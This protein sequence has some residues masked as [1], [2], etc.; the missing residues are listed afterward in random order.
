MVA[1]VRDALAVS[2]SEEYA[3]WRERHRL[4]SEENRRKAGAHRWQQF[5]VHLVDERGDCIPD[6]YLEL[7]TRDATGR[8]REIEDFNLDFH[9]YRDDTSFRC[10]VSAG[11][12]RALLH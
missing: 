11:R 6:Y 10:V 12:L 8:F 5:I 7:Y 3:A 9:E 2:S 1:S 4:L